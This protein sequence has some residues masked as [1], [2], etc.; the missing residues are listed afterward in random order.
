MTKDDACDR[1][2]A[3]RTLPR[4]QTCLFWNTLDLDGEG[5]EADGGYAVTEYRTGRCRR[6]PPAGG[7]NAPSMSEGFANLMDAANSSVW[8]VTW[9]E[10]WCG[11]H[12]ALHLV[13]VGEAERR[14]FTI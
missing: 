6:N 5:H 13:S 9:A 1:V 3:Q 7:R 12:S 11:Q 8:P 4:C 10:D 14:G 2:L